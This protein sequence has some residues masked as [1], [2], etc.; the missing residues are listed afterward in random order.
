[1]HR[2]RVHAWLLLLLVIGLGEPLACLLHCLPMWASMHAVAGAGH[3]HDMHSSMDG[4]HVAL[5]LVAQQSEESSSLAAHLCHHLSAG[6]PASDGIQGIAHGLHEHL[7]ALLAVALVPGLHLV[8]WQIPFAY[9]QR[10]RGV[11]RPP[12]LRPPIMPTS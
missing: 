12:D 3:Q 8:R 10:L 6:L 7:A 9:N 4:G 1:M 5:V 2:N 11:A